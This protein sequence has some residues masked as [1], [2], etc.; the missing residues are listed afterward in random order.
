MVSN[1]INSRIIN[2]SNFSFKI[3]EIK[4]L[5]SVDKTAK[6]GRPYKALEVFVDNETRKVNIF[7]NAPDFANIHQG[8]T[9][10]G[11]MVKDGNFWNI[12]FEGVTP[13]NSAPGAFKTAQVKEVM[14]IKRQDI[15]RSQEN[16]DWSI[17]VSSTMRDAVQLAVAEY[18]INKQNLDRLDECILKW[19]KWLLENWEVNEKDYN[20][21]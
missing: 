21:F 4:V 12:S 8:S 16:K 17:R 20:P 5:S 2:N 3:M 6:T 14:N 13:R 9:I 1:S 19:R 11:T 15:A 7:S 10:L 18:T